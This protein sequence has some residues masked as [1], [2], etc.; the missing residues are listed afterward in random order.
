MDYAFKDLKLHRVFL[1]VFKNN[2]AAVTSYKKVGFEV[3]GIARDMVYLDD[4]YHNMI[5]M[6][7]I[8]G[9]ESE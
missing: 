5:F 9:E 3:E 7:M 2:T 4:E 6:S 8:N 1:R